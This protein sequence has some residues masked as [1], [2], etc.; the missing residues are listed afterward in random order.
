MC[1]SSIMCT[2]K[3]EYTGLVHV[4]ANSSCPMNIRIFI[5]FFLDCAIVKNDWDLEIEND[6]W[7]M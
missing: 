3:D 6:F 5:L 7:I 2:I 4:W 1:K